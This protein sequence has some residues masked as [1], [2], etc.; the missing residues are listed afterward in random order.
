MR[1][2]ALED[3]TTALNEQLLVKSIANAKRYDL[4]QFA[5]AVVL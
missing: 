4:P 3:D 5:M 2:M 1:T